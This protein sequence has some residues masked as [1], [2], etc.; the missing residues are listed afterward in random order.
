MTAVSG[1]YLRMIRA[2]NPGPMTLEGTNTWLVGNPGRGAVVVVDPGPLLDDHLD[3]IVEA[4]PGGIAAVVLTHRHLDHSEG[5]AALAEKAGCGVRAADPELRVGT[6]G[7]EDGDRLEVPGA[8]LTMVP[9][10][11]HTSDSV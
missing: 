2:A 8:S 7:L 11:G 4:A 5:A 6:D 10:P 9:T 3:A 1:P